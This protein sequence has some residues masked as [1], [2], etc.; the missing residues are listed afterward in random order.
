M[1]ELAHQSRVH[2]RLESPA[3]DGRKRPDS[4]DRSTTPERI[5]RNP[6]TGET[7]SASG[8]VHGARYG[9]DVEDTEDDAEAVPIWSERYELV[10]EDEDERSQRNP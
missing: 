5:F 3:P 10:G 7:I 1:D 4:V 2:S 6:E 9:F 8:I